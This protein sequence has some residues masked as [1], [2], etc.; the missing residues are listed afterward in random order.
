MDSPL[1][2]WGRSGT[3]E[4]QA[5]TPMVRQ[6]RPRETLRKARTMVGSKWVPEHAT[7]SLRATAGDSGRLYGRAVVIVS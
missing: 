4:I 2:I 7:S 1:L 3:W 5:L 6:R